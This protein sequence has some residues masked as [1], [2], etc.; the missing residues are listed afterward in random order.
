MQKKRYRTIIISDI[1][2]GKP[3]SQ[4][5]R[6]L[7]FLKKYTTETLIIDGDFIDF[8]QLNLLGKRTEK[9]TN[10]VNHIIKQVNKGMKLIYIKGN[11][12]AFIRKLHHLHFP[13]M[14]IV[15]DHILTTKNGKTYY[16]THGEWFDFINHHIIRFGKLA[17]LFYTILYL[18]EKLF[19]KHMGK[20]GYIP[21]AERL[22]IRF[23]KHL[24]PQKTLQRKALRLAEKMLCDGI[25]IGHYHLPDHVKQNEKEYFNTGD[26]MTRCTAV[27]ENDKGELELIQYKK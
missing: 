17:N 10:V 21:F 4:A 5:E 8:R 23:K 19:N 24:F 25:I 18:T 9:E 13:N 3:N 20:K 1:H 27:M 15:S 14:S 16:L 26:R 12:D 6:L 11:H 7:E 2:L 22:K